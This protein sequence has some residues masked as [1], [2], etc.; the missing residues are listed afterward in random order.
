MVGKSTTPRRNL[1][2]DHASANSTTVKLASKMMS[3]L[4]RGADKENAV[5]QHQRIQELEATV[6]ALQASPNDAL[7]PDRAKDVHECR[8][9]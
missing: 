4:L 5:S 3:T 8:Q 9:C 6:S 2:Q 7:L 1:V